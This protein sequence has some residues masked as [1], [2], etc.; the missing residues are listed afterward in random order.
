MAQTEAADRKTKLE[1]V[2]QELAAMKEVLA[3]EQEA[4]LKTQEAHA[5]LSEELNDA[6]VCA[7]S[8]S[9]S[10]PGL[11]SMTQDREARAA[12]FSRSL[13]AAQADL[14]TAFAQVVAQVR[15][16]VGAPR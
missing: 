4:H 16:A 1:Q 10:N 15:R 8:P 2:E 7:S 3:A 11:K 14:E 5:T 6:L 12:E 9:V 13:L